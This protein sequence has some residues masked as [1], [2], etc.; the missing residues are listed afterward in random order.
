MDNPSC[1]LAASFSPPLPTSAEC[2]LLLFTSPWMSK[3]DFEELHKDLLKLID[4]D[5]LYWI[6]NEAK[7]RATRQGCTF[8]EFD[9]IVK[10]SH[11]N[12]VTSHDIKE[13]KKNQGVNWNPKINQGGQPP[14][15]SSKQFQENNLEGKR[16][17]TISTS[18]EYTSVPDLK[19][20]NPFRLER[21]FKNECYS[22]E[23]LVKIFIDILDN[24][25][26]KHGCNSLSNSSIEN[27]KTFIPKEDLKFIWNVIKA[28]HHS[29]RL[30]INIGFLSKKQ[31]RTILNIT[32]NVIHSIELKE[33]EEEQ[34]KVLER[35][36][37]FYRTLI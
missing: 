19:S 35:N 7:F 5:S 28:V 22:S 13:L 2:S 8:E 4:E 36:E 26:T 23:L 24:H 16:P 10:T 30:D 15:S 21:A 37:T 33:E 3:L 27:L 1:Q 11:L 18:I 31:I 29:N 12:P 20:L 34:I 9:A 17:S 14:A 6:R 32:R 25:A